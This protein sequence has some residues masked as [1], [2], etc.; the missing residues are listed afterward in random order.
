MMNN[1]ELNEK[2]LDEEVMEKVNGGI[3]HR[4]SGFSG[5]DLSDIVKDINEGKTDDK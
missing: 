1:A 3:N 5:P 4:R 2:M